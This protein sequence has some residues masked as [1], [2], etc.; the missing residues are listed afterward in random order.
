MSKPSKNPDTK[1]LNMIRHASKCGWATLT[2]CGC[3]ASRK[4]L[5]LIDQLANKRAL[6]A[7]IDEIK[8]AEP[9]HGMMFFH[10]ST[11]QDRIAERK[12]LVEG[13]EL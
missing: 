12:A 10:D 11:A 1:L 4:A 9:V 5:T 7:R 3:G 8:G 13:D 2:D 6:E